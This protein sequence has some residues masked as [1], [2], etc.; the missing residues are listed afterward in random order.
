MNKLAL[1][2]ASGHGKVVADAALAAGW[3]HVVFFDDAWPG[4]RVN[5]RWPVVGDMTVL[6]SRLPEFDGVLVAIGNC[7]VRWRKQQELRSAGARLATVVH[8]RACVSSYAQLGEG[9]V[10]MAGLMSERNTDGNSGIP[11]L[12]DVPV[13]G[14]LFKSRTRSTNKTELVLMIVPYIIESDERATAV[15][16]AIVDRLQ[17]LELP[18]APAAAVSTPGGQP[19]AIGR[20][21]GGLSA[22]P[23]APPAADPASSPVPS[24]SS[25]PRL[26][27]P[28]APV[29]PGGPR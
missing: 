18:P 2:G 8:P 1:L 10:V 7:A 27:S 26:Q 11:L 28:P 6:M 14:N 13:L 23:S 17:L 15:S 9:S 29:S 22:R 24:N 21:P 16:Q 5:G 25:P 12:K 3:K 19:S 20:A 4:V